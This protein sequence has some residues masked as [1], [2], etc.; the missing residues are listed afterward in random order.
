MKVDTTAKRLL[1][2]TVRIEGSL[3]SGE[4]SVGTGFVLS[5]RFADY[6]DELFIVTNKHVVDGVEKSRL[7]F[8]RRVAE[9]PVLGHTFGLECGEGFGSAFHGHPDTDVDIAVMP[10][11]YLLEVARKGDRDAFLMNINT[12][13]IPNNAKVESYDAILPVVFVGYPSGLYD[14]KHMTPI[15]R[16]GTTATPVQLDYDNRPVFLIDAS[17]FPGSSGSPVFAFDESWEGGIA[18]LQLLG[19]LAEVFTLTDSGE[20]VTIPAPTQQVSQIQIRQMLD[21]GVV[22]KSYLIVETILHCWKCRESEL[23][24]LRINK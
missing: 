13:L 24:R 19:I 3:K 15:V 7:C 5:H 18:E 4:T 20:L 12:E 10:I 8:T 22:F 17:V 9:Q 1:F 23:R 6:G 11:S 2:S 14:R 21:L 16:R